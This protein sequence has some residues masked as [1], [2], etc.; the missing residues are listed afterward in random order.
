[1]GRKIEIELTEQQEK[2]LKLFAEKQF[3]GAED[4]L[5]TSNAIHVVENYRPVY[6]PYHEDQIDYFGDLPLQ[7]TTDEAH[8]VWFN[9]EVEAVKDWFESNETEPHIEI[10]SFKELQYTD[11]KTEDGEDIFV[12]NYDDYFKVYGIDYYT[13]TWL[14]DNYE[15]EAFFFIRDEAKRYLDYQKHNL[16]KPRIYTYSS[17]Y[18]NNGDF[19]HFRNLLMRMGNKLNKEDREVS[20]DII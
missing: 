6:L 1:M 20:C 7:F 15:P 9:S 18:A 19:D 14:Q 17:G 16:R 2:F 8:E 11:A 3:N 4:N 5:Y 10:V 13:A 12:V